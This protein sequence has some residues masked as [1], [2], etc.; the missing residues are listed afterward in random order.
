M[1]ILKENKN[2]GVVSLRKETQLICYKWICITKLNIYGNIHE[3]ISYVKL[4]QTRG[5]D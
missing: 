4:C 1:V 3:L 2:W 5:I